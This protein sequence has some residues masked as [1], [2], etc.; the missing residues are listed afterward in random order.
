M[1]SD[2][3]VVERAAAAAQEVVFF[4]FDADDI[5]DYDVTITFEDGVFEVDV[6]VNAPSGTDDE[7]GVAEDAALAA[8]TAFDELFDHSESAA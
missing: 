4:R 6:Y 7:D 1:V 2:A 3:A 8:R 5:E